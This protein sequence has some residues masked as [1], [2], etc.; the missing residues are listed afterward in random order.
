M[1]RFFSLVLV[2]A[3]VM[4]LNTAVYSVNA[5]EIVGEVEMNI[6][7][8][9]RLTV[10]TAINDYFHSRKAFLLGQE[11]TINV[12]LQGVIDDEEVHKQ[13][14]ESQSIVFVNSEIYI[15]DIVS[16]DTQA[17]AKVTETVTYLDSGVSSTATVT[18]DLF[19]A[20]NDD[21]VPVVIHDGYYEMFSGFKS[22][23]YVDEDSVATMN[24]VGGSGNCL[25]Y[26]AEGELGEGEDA[27]KSTKYGEWY[28][29]YSGDTS[30]IAANWCVMFVSWCAKEANISNDVI[31][32]IGGEDIMLDFFALQNRYYSRSVAI[33]SLA[34]QVGD[35]IFFSWDGIQADHVGIVSNVDANTISVI[36]GNTP[37]NNV[38]ESVY[39]RN[40][41][42]I[43][44]Y[45]KPAYASADHTTT[46]GY[47]HDGEQHWL[48]C[49][50]CGCEYE[51]GLHSLPN[52]YVDNATHH[53]KVCSTCGQE[54]VRESHTF[55][56]V[57]AGWVFMCTECG[58]VEE[59]WG[60][61]EG[62]Q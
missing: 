13:R 17:D 6:S 43:L 42:S 18:H 37:E 31:Y 25:V 20:L 61:R 15:C 56:D 7:G 54:T 29:E 58:Y 24:T 9:D 35:I 49:D 53:W 41:A 46:S 32:Y 12:P 27:D 62:A 36:E 45:A 3:M 21:N 57:H 28:A 51:M 22:C 8:M 33:N 19:L 52:Y 26:T 48:N 16:S 40:N 1:K 30:F 55:E 23:A 2:L 5:A 11:D 39:N 44:G 38:A 34:P 47:A 50:N 10:S 60:A 4:S 59:N 14:Y